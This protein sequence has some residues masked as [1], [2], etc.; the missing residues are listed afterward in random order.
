MPPWHADPA[1]GS[2]PTTAVSAT[3]TRTRSSK[4][5]AA[6]AP[7]GNRADLPAAPAYPTGWSIGQPDAV[8]QMTEA[9]P[10][11][12]SG[13]IDYKHFE[14]PTNLTEDKWIQ[15]FEFKPAARVRRAPH[16]CLC[17]C[18]AAARSGSA[19]AARRRRLLRLRA[20]PGPPSAVHDGVRDE[21]AG[22][23]PHRDGQAGDA[24]RS[25]GPEGGLGAFVGGVRS[26]PGRS[27]SI[28]RAPR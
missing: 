17:A 27:A 16:H 6:G 12:A 11:P 22:R 7:E 18:P 4:W 20:L 8:F 3:P 10:V 25:A 21:H 13:T 26:G 19:A 9:Y 2:S 24:Q 23:A 14:V 1:Y 5:V 15:A 28:R